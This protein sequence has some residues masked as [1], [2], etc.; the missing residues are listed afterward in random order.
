MQA[1]RACRG[2]RFTPERPRAGRGTRP[3]RQAARRAH[4]ST[5]P[6][7]EG[8]RSPLRRHAHAFGTSPRA[9]SGA[10][11]M[12]LLAAMTARAESSPALARYQVET[13]SDFDSFLR[14]ESIWNELLEQSGT[15]FPF[16]THEWMRS[17]IEFFGAEHRLH[18]LLVKTGR[19][20]VGIAPLMLNQGW[21]YG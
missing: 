6:H 11:P 2:D 20:V 5:R 21:M 14:L 1:I 17:W 3:R 4:V 18:M 8:D 9:R 16:V 15:S 13:L 7:G 10:R 19:T 12:S